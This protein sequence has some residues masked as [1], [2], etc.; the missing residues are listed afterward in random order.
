[1]YSFIKNFNFLFLL[2]MFIFKLIF[3]SLFWY[4]L[5]FDFISYLV[6]ANV[7][8]KIRKNLFI[9][10]LLNFLF[11]FFFLFLPASFP[12]Y[13]DGETFR[14]YVVM[15]LLPAFEGEI[16]TGTGTAIQAITHWNYASICRGPGSLYQRL[17]KEG[18]FAHLWFC[19]EKNA[20]FFFLWLF[21]KN[22]FFSFHVLYEEIHNYLF[23]FI[24][25]IFN[26]VN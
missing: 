5:D 18:K 15:P 14:V 9:L 10:Y 12:Y 4:K 20:R 8:N 25:S 19:W 24:K 11:L 17:Q 3:F 26:W 16:G 1:M 7:V 6:Y 23:L 21:F 2:N 22:R 13:R